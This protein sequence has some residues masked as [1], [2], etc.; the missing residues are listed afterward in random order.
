MKLI[1][2]IFNFDR[3]NVTNWIKETATFKFYIFKPIKILIRYRRR[4]KILDLYS[5]L[6]YKILFFIDINILKGG[7]FTIKRIG[8]VR[9]TSK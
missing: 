8:N 9:V 6:F 2:F 5:H 4:L 7:G 3:L 1:F